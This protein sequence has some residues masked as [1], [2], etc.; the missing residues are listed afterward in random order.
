MAE[1]QEIPVLVQERISRGRED[2]RRDWSKRR[3]CQ[4]FER[5]E[6]YHHLTPKGQMVGVA[7]GL[8][9]IGKVDKPGHR[10][11]NTYNFVRPIVQGKVSAA[12]QR[13][14]S[15]EC[16][17]A[18][19]D[20][21]DVQA[22]R[23]AEKVALYGYDKWGVRRASVKAATLAIGGGGEAF[24]LPYFDPNVAPFT[25]VGVNEQ[26]GEP[27]MVGQGEIKLMVLDGNQVYW[28]PGIE[29]EDSRWWAIER[30][31][32]IEEVREIPGF[33][34][35][36]LV[37]DASEDGKRQNSQLV[38]VT[39]Y[40]ERPCQKYPEGR[41]IVMANRRVIVDYRKVN[42]QSP[43]VWEPYPLRSRDGKVIDEPVLHR[44][45]WTTSADGYRDL[46]LTWQ[47]V[48]AQRTINDCW[49]KVLEW[50]NRALHP[51]MIAPAGSNVMRGADEPGGVDYYQVMGNGTLKPE[52]EQVPS[53]L[54]DPLFRIMEK[55]QSDMREIGFDTQLTAEANVA[56]RTVNAVIEQYQAK[57]Q[58]FL[59]DLADWHSRVM[60][61]CLLLVS[62]HY[63]ESR[64]LAIRGR[65]GPESIAAFDGAQLLDQVDVRVL[66]GSLDFLT[67]DQMIQ[68][69]FAY[70]DRGWISPQQ[71]M[72]AVNSGTADALVQ[73]MELDV[74][75]VDRVIQKIR[76]GSVMEM[77]L[78]QDTMID[79]M[80][81]V[82]QIMEV[83]SYM[84]SEHDELGVWRQRMGDW[85][86]TSEFDG[87][88][89]GLQEVAQQIMSGIEFLRVVG[90]QRQAQQQS[91]AAEQLGMENAAKPV[92]AKPLP[93]QSSPIPEGR[94]TSPTGLPRF[95]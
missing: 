69:V 59:G 63:S 80:S 25:Q 92:K 15:Y 58:A 5:G 70:A 71:A 77:P 57:W 12:T 7:S 94:D 78:R 62:V 90:Q 34:G 61:H 45:C 95:T 9:P 42:P 83:P 30:A 48:D 73:S 16:L 33:F 14:P 2:M 38:I 18:T 23:L 36:P 79:P 53:G 91:A 74:A 81:G 65:F 44:L 28:E 43:Y 46:G 82:P 20:P 93:D 89:P 21:E 56:A 1:P 88:D 68:R 3:L 47:L 66:P 64:K 54:A 72:L 86:K 11:R 60:R 6:N 50:K 40:F 75:R 19:T 41:R 37:G 76:D 55:M 49:N 8:D 85:M 13:I 32:T 22:A 67:K 39:E 87:L 4:L 26:T 24:C 35:E 29:F 84:P 10:I 52:W 51:R 31:R 27:E 17:P